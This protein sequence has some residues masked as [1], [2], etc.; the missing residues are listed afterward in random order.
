MRHGR[1]GSF[2]SSIVASFLGRSFGAQ[3]RRLAST[4]GKEPPQPFVPA[5]A[6]APKIDVS[7][8][9]KPWTG[10]PVSPAFDAER[11]G[12]VDLQWLS[13]APEAMARLRR[14]EFVPPTAEFWKQSTEES[15][16]VITK[17]ISYLEIL[18][19]I[20]EHHWTHLITDALLADD[21]PLPHV[22]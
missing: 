2:R 11:S 6:A 18:H 14:L 10:L 17:N 20:S 1:T 9:K 7:A 15:L 16:E 19:L 4:P 12:E 22:L 21:A 8:L 5:D 13:K 3:A